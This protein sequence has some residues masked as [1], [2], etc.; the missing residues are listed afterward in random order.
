MRTRWSSALAVALP[1]GLVACSNSSSTQSGPSGVV[2]TLSDVKQPVD[3][4]GASSAFFGGNISDAQ[5]DLL[6]DAKKGIG[7]SLLRIMI[8]VP[9]DTQ[10]DGSEPTTGANPVATAPEIATAQ[11]AIARGA[12]VWAAA[13][14]PPPIWKT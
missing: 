4:F 7:L 10:S 14:T 2:V 11:Q 5:A 6:F 12:K 8:G 1:L 13:W 9:N 3:G